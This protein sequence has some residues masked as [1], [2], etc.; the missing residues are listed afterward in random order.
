MKLRDYQQSGLADIRRA[1]KVHRRVLYRLSTGGGKTVLSGSMLGGAAERGKRAWFVVH[2]KELVEQTSRTLEKIGIDHGF[3][4]NGFPPRY[5]KAV[6]LCSVQTLATR[7]E[8]LPRPDLICWDEAHHCAAGTWNKVAAHFPDALHIGLTATPERLDGKGLMGTFNVLVPGPE[9]SWL[10]ENGYLARYRIWAPATPDMS[11]VKM[12]GHDFDGAEAA[13]VMNKAKITGDIVAH[14]QSICPHTQAVAFCCNVSHAMALRDAFRAA[15]VVCEELDGSAPPDVRRNV[16]RAYREGRIK[17]LTSVDLFGEGFDL[18]ELGAAILARP[19]QSLGLYL[20]QVGRA[21]RPVYAEGFDLDTIEGRM[22][23]QAAGPKPHAFILDHAGNFQRHGAPDEDREW[24]IQGRRKR[25]G[26][27]TGPPMR[28][29]PSCFATVAAAT[30]SCPHCQHEF[31]GAVRQ[32]DEVD[33]MLAEIDLQVR[34]QEMKREVRMAR[35]REEL[36][37]IARKRGY[38]RGWVDHRMKF[39]RREHA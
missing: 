4:A 26:K 1:L 18:P 6:T 16:V 15:G 30:A 20:Q 22:A 36:E 39:V 23:A 27:K 9:T 35:T 10:I 28:Q 31:T 25:K 24:S 12:R 21:L 2:R 17:V 38:K 37:A 8:R 5:N 34:K 13:A 3:C 33:G 29:C 11:G 32:V 7:F 14:Y 19:T